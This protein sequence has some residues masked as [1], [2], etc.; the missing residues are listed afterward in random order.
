MKISLLRM[1]EIDYII[2]KAYDVISV[3][4]IKIAKGKGY[5]G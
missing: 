1:R 3:H 4:N 2:I 5:E